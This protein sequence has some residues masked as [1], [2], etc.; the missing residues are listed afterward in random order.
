MAKQLQGGGLVGGAFR[1]SDGLIRWA[2]SLSTRNY[3]SILWLDESTGI[4]YSG[5]ILKPSQLRDVIV[6]EVKAPQAGEM[7]R[8]GSATG[9]V[10]ECQI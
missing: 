2:T 9:Q 3:L 4:W 7:I 6:E 5:G 8:R 1:C 10:R